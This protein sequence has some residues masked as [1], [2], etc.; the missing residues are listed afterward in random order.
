MAEPPRT[1]FLGLL[2]VLLHHGIDFLVVGGVAAQLAGAPILTLDLDVLYDKSPG[3]LDRLLAA[4]REIKARYRDPAGRHIEPD[5]EKLET[6]RMHLLLTELGAL[7][8]LGEIGAG[9][10]FQ[11]LAGRTVSYQL[12]EAR[13]RILELAAVIE[14]K[15]HANR[16]K[17]RAVLPVLRQTLAMKAALDRDEEI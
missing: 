10:D 7:D 14:T 9:L 15:E 16:A 17:D 1:S 6:L 3:N 13:V 11:A 12:G 8:L 5:R 2:R 4:L